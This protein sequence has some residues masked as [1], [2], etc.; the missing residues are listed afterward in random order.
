MR[1]S[2]W[3]AS[4]RS[5]LLTRPLGA[6]LSRPLCETLEDRWV[7]APLLGLDITNNLLRF[8]STAPTTILSTVPVIGL[9]LG[10]DLL[11]IDYRP[12]TGQLYGLG[13]TGRLY[14]LDEVTGDA[15]QVGTG[16]FA[17]ALSGTSF[18]FDFNPTVDKI[19]VVSDL[20]QNFRLNPLTGAQVDSDPATAGTQLDADLNPAGVNVI[21][22]A[23]TNNRAGVATTTLYGI[24]FT[25]DQLVL[26]GGL[27]G[28]PSPNLGAITAVGLL[29]FDTTSD[30]GFD[31]AASGIVFAS[32]TD[33][34]ALESTLVTIDLISGQATK[35]GDIAAGVP[36]RGLAVAPFVVTVID[37][38]GP[39]SLRQAILDANAS[40][41]TD[42]ITFNLFGGGVQIINPLS[43]LP[44]ITEAVILQ[45]ASAPGFAGTPLI[46]IDGILA[47][48]VDRGLVLRQHT[49]SAIN[50]LAITSFGSN[51]IFIDGGGA[52]TLTGNYIGLDPDG[53]TVTSNFDDGILIRN[54][55]TNNTI[56]GT[57]VAARNVIAGNLNSGIAIYD[58]GT[59]GNVVSG[60]YIGTDASGAKAAGNIAGVFLDLGASNNTIGGTATGAGNVISGNAAGMFILGPETTG[61]VVQGNRIG[62]NAAG[63]AAVPNDAGGIL[64][65][66]AP[67]ANTIGG[68]V[69]GAGN[70]ISGNL[71]FG[72]T[73]FGD[74]KTT[75]IQGNIIGLDA[76]GTKVLAN[77]GFG[78]SLESGA[79]GNT[80]G[81]TTA[82]EANVISGNTDS[83]VNFQNQTT[84]A[85]LLSGNLIGTNGANDALGNVRNGVTLQE[86]ATGNTISGNVIVANQKNG[87]EMF[88]SDVSD[89]AVRGNFIGVTPTDVVRPNGT[90]VLIRDGASGNWIGSFTEPNVISGNTNA[91]VEIA[92]DNFL[93]SDNNRIGNNFIGTA[94]SAAT[95]PNGT[96]IIIRGLAAN[97]A[98]TNGVISGNT[99]AGVLITGSGTTGTLV[100]MNF[101]GTDPLV[102]KLIPNGAGGVVVEATGIQI[103]SNLIVGNTG[104]GITLRNS[105]SGNTLDS[106]TI[107]F[108]PFVLGALPNT[109]AGI[110]LETSANN[111]TIFGNNIAGNLG[112][113]I[114]LR[115]GATGNLVQGNFVGTSSV[116][117]ISTNLPNGGNGITLQAVSGNLIGD[118]AAG[119]GNRI[120]NNLGHGIALLGA[121]GNTLLG[122][123]IGTD[124]AGTANLGNQLSGIFFDTNSSNNTV[125]SSAGGANGN[126]IAFNT[127]DGITL[128]TGVGNRIQGN[129]IYAN[130]KLGIDL[131]N[132]GPTANQPSGA[133]NFP[134]ITTANST[135]T[136]GLITGTLD[137]TPNSVFEI[138]LFS[139]TVGDPSGFG[140]G[141]TSLGVV[142]IITD[143]TGA[144]TFA[145]TLRA[146]L[147]AGAVVT[148]TATNVGTG[149]TSEFSATT[150]AGTDLIAPTVTLISTA[151]DPTALAS[152]P[153]MV[154]FSEPI[155]N[156][157]LSDLT[158]VNG[159]I[160]NFVI[161]SSTVATFTLVP[162]NQ[163]TVAVT[164]A[165]GAAQDVA[166]ND[167]NAATLSRLF[168]TVAPTVVVTPGAG[169][170]NPGT[171]AIVFTVTFS[172]PVTGFDSNDLVIG[173]TAGA[174][175]GTVTG[176]GSTYTVSVPAPTQAGTVTLSV[177]GNAAVDAAGNSSALPSGTPASVT[178][179]LGTSPPV[180]PLTQPGLTQVVVSGSS[181][182]ANVYNFDAAG[183]LTQV[184]SA[185]TPFPG[186]PG[187]VRGASGDINGDGVVDQVF[188]T[189]PGGGD[190]VRIVSGKD[191]SDLLTAGTF[192]AY[193]GENFT[194]IGLFVAVGDID[195]DG[196]AEVVVSPDQ[197]G[198]AR[199]QVFRFS[200]GSLVQVGNFF[201]I[202]DPAF[203]GGGR[204]A[205]GDIDGDGKLDMIVGAG[206]GGGPRIALFNG[207]DLTGNVQRPR[208]LIGDFVIFEPGLRDGVFVAA[209]D[210]NGDGKADLVF[211][212]GPG[213]GPR[214]TALDAAAVLTSSDPN[215]TGVKNTPLSNFFAFDA[216]QR[217]G[218]RVTVK[219]A[220]GDSKLDLVVGSGDGVAPAV[221]TYRGADV[222]TA[223]NGTE[224]T[225][226]QSL[227]PFGSSALANG[228][229][230]G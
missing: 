125:G 55:S 59:T 117:T 97:N 21:G 134:V 227:A 33:P 43:A 217:G 159:T 27:D 23:Y 122:N 92:G 172:E 150:L 174:T 68:A 130:G 32:L 221:K 188:V 204:I 102:T 132:D 47:S 40:L 143:A 56:G 155:T 183:Q 26:Q 98:I 167:N 224:P 67:F 52:H 228:V 161:V 38:A 109:T 214:V 90:G 87:I 199:I 88:G 140:E 15:V 93:S 194:T 6:K 195:G 69:A 219:Q 169:Q 24:D 215:L 66:D 13:S 61:N 83:G 14:T 17:V 198:G 12:A 49:G 177:V 5:S 153:V 76:T 139:N 108:D 103:S 7:P 82:A 37:D 129:R 34:L 9:Q 137:S 156:F 18:G 105:A 58:V 50:N 203:R 11:G 196:T 96:G 101:I 107:G 218:V 31:I 211:G 22:S 176:S 128:A 127:L 124:T 70:L 158:P 1:L 110:V 144:A 118:A 25:T 116:G 44:D 60:N 104:A 186:I 42:V 162:T 179:T 28:V 163:G 178:F 36:L 53:L 123:E 191:G 115:T 77:T 154:T 62:T 35:V 207:L 223:A 80:I 220:D 16:T 91:G 89:N 106:N 164:L 57:T 165:A 193:A 151:L 147:A 182:L 175:K 86:A 180:V 81:G 190:R 75:L 226:L 74:A 113:G 189:G 64:L 39:G 131:G 95:L 148:A 79:T 2:R 63:T 202:E 185:V 10:E 141:E 206:F 173:G 152:I 225:V 119:K 51:G 210:L 41:G 112:D 135:A 160:Q 99:G 4:A 111:N 73:L 205:L 84:T 145:F 229:F 149:T 100:E 157:T 3:F 54:K 30:V 71:G 126:L 171:T 212:G 208:K 136:G 45:G 197:G 29:D 166:G 187:L 170:P 72:I 48:F 213:G 146:P 192:N 8:D 121:N 216:N 133:Q 181:S 209:G 230:V 19:R 168:D 20:G 142:R 201:G 222:L 200:A 184:G 65:A 114:T 78:I 46:Q 138:E 94:K 85:N 120:G